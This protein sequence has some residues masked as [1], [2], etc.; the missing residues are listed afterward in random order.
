MR[1]SDRFENALLYA[2]RLHAAQIRKG[3]TTPYVS[4]LMAVAAIVLEYGGTEDEAIAALLHDA[5]EDQGGADVRREIAERF[6]ESVAVI[7]DG[8]SDTDVEP[9]PPWKPRKEHHLSQL[10]S[11]SPSVA[12]VAAADKLHNATSILRDRRE[13]GPR[14]WE[15]FT[16][17]R[18][19]TMWYYST[20]ADVLTANAPPAL[21]A[22]LRRVL[23]Q[24]ST[25][26]PAAT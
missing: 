7:V 10:A 13:C 26:G 8:C 6:G 3:T 1:L 24:L 9:K 4:H 22:D 17:G 15:R 5:V 12:M 25:C 18:E 21:I 19:G 2:T 14:V 23:D 16:G 20:A 11:A